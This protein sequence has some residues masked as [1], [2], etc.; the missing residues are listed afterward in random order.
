MDMYLEFLEVVVLLSIFFVS[1]IVMNVLVCMLVFKV[2]LMRNY[3]NGFVVF[4]VIL[5]ILIGVVFFL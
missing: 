5:D 1:V 2:K 4:L 3:I